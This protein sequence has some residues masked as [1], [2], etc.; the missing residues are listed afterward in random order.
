MK[1]KQLGKKYKRKPRRTWNYENKLAKSKRNDKVWKKVERDYKDKEIT[2]TS[3][4]P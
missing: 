3:K 4:L 1:L 2:P